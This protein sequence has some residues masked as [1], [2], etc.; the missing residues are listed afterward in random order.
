[1]LDTYENNSLPM[2]SLDK[3]NLDFGL[4]RYD[5]RVTLPIVIE[6]TGEVVAQ[7]RLA[8]KVDEVRIF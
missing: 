1:M 4:V 8:P 6:N 2:V 5:Q 7:F 3:L